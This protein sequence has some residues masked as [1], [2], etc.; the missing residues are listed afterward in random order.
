M[1]WGY[2]S[3]SKPITIGCQFMI[4]DE[5]IEETVEIIQRK[6]IPI[7]SILDAKDE[8]R[9]I[10]L[11][12]YNVELKRKVRKAKMVELGKPNKF[13]KSEQDQIL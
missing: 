2:K 12:F 9:K 11:Q 5:K 8:N 7:E 4:K 13:F 1:L 3:S 6:V 10:L